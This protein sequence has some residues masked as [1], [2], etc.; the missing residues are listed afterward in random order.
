MQV[1]QDRPCELTA[2][3]LKRRHRE[4]YL[5]HRDYLMIPDPYWRDRVMEP[6]LRAMVRDRISTALPPSIPTVGPGRRA[7]PSR[8]PLPR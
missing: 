2:R 6:I 1:L 5:G 3:E 8:L 4:T 7:A